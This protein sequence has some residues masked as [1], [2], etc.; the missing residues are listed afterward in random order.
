MNLTLLVENNPKIESFYML[1]L[2]TWLGLETISK[3]KGEFAVKY[4]ETNADKLRLII[5]R[6][7]IGK[8]QTAKWYW[9]T[10]KAII[11]LFR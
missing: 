7:Q 6:S 3:N 5:V 1:N 2:S 9:N 11:S 10:L 8:E 4:L